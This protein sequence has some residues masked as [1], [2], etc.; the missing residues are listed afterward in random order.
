MIQIVEVNPE[1]EPVFTQSDVD[2]FV[3]SWQLR[4]AELKKEIA[5]LKGELEH[6]RT[7]REREL[8][9]DMLRVLH[10]CAVVAYK[11]LDAEAKKIKADAIH[12]ITRLSVQN[13]RFR[14]ML[15]MCYVCVP[16][17]ELADEIRHVLDTV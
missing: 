7:E 1:E 6:L 17:G 3:G 4:N 10:D 15:N 2:D 9:N 14:E 13:M 8:G 5:D 16:S 11:E 12:D